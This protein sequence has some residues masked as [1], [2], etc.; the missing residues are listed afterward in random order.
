MNIIA[1]YSLRPSV[2]IFG[3]PLSRRNNPIYTAL[4][5]NYI[6]VLVVEEDNSC[7]SSPHINEIINILEE[8]LGEKLKL[9]ICLREAVNNLPYISYYSISTVA[10]SLFL[11]ELLELD[12][13]DITESLMGVE[14]EL[15]EHELIQVLQALRLSIINDR[16]LLYRYGE[17][18]IIVDHPRNC[19]ILL[20]GRETV[21]TKERLIY[22]IEDVDD[23][24]SNLITKIAG[25]IV[26]K[27]YNSIHR[28]LLD[29]SLL[30]VCCRLENMIWYAEYK[31]NPPIVN[32][33]FC[34][35][36][37]PNIGKPIQIAISFDTNN[38]CNEWVKALC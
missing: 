19:F 9:N 6:K 20:K 23:E 21:E 17:E 25:L 34:T 29:S 28:Q 2:A 7:T 22:R 30:N 4:L 24:L 27:A 38:K 26:I 15:F 11:S 14:T 35:K 12:V 13:K 37:I 16:P 31:L 10:L 32:D 18:P 3:V 5:T 1:E 33:E 36:W 8:E